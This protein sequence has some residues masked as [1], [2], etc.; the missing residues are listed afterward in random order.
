MTGVVRERIPVGEF[1]RAEFCH[2][3]FLTDAWFWQA[4]PHGPRV[5]FQKLTPTR[6]LTYYA[7]IWCDL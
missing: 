6:D 4:K 3:D 1:E 7:D 5:T 2:A